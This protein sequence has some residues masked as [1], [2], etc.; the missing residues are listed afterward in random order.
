MSCHPCCTANDL[1]HVTE[2]NQMTCNYIIPFFNYFHF[3]N[4]PRPGCV[5]AARAELELNFFLKRGEGEKEG[6]KK[7][8]VRIGKEQAQ[9]PGVLHYVVCLHNVDL[10]HPRELIVSS[11]YQSN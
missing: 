4:P 8:K 3:C 10:R 9:R 11:G 1:S 5:L 2:H 6:G 7:I